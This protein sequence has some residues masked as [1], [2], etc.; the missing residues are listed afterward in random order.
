MSIRRTEPM[1]RAA[2]TVVQMSRMLGMSRASFHDHMKRGTFL[3]P[4]YAVATRRPFFTAE[5]QQRNL[6]ARATQTGVNGEFVLFYDRQSVSQTATRPRRRSGS[7][8]QLNE[9][10][11]LRARLEGLGLMT[12]TDDMVLSAR[13]ECF[14]QGTAGVTDSDVLRVVYRHLRRSQGV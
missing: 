1:F 9:A 4:V 10:G 2:V 12:L 6:E 13:T 14:P 11:D 3:P 7:V 5:M 8:T